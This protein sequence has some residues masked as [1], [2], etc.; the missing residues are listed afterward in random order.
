MDFLS[1][2][3][4]LMLQRSMD[5]LWTKQSC[6]LDNIANA[7]TPGYKTKYATFEEAL[8]QAVQSAD[9]KKGRNVRSGA[10]D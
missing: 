4:A 1:S 8:Q 6:I 10:V 7:E 9:K 2:N 5:Y 3:T